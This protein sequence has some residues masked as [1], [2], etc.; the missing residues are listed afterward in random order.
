MYIMWLKP[1][2]MNKKNNSRRNFIKKTS[3]LPGLIILPRHVLG[4]K[5]YKAP[6]DKLN[7]AGVGVRKYGMGSGNLHAC[8]EEN[9]VALCDVDFKQS[10]STFKKYPKAKVYKDFRKMFEKQKDIDAV[11]VA[12]PDHNHA[13]IRS[14][15]HTS[16]LQSHS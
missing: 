5:G 6:S 4:G 12:T 15:E 13:V 9:I 1:K 14:E 16:E 10:A 7:I 8:R 3:V 11:I 2:K